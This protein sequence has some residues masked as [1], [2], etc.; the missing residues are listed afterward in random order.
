MVETKL[1]NNLIVKKARNGKGIFANKNFEKGNEILR[2][3]KE[4]LIKYEEIVYDK[5]EDK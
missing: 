1:S 5:N 4:K 2:Y 3:P